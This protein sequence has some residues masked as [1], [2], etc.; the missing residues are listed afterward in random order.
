MYL[1]NVAISRHSWL[2]MLLAAA[3][4]VVCTSSLALSEEDEIKL[5]EQ[6]HRKII[7]QYGVYRDKDLQEYINKV[8]QR[9]A[10]QSSRPDLEFHFTILDDTMI[11]A[12]ALPGGYVY[13]TRGIL[14]HLN[15]E[16]ELA[17]V[18]GHEIAHVTEKHAI[19]SQNRGKALGALSTVA[20]VLTGTPGVFELGNMFGGV[21]LKGYSREFELE[22]DRV[23]ASYMAKAGYSPQ[24]MLKTIEILKAKDRIE[25]E[26]ARIEKREPRVYHG[27]LSTH[28]DND[29]RYKEA[30]KESNKLL[31]NYS[32]FIKADEFL[33]KLNGLAYGESHQVGVVRKN[34]FYHPKLGIKMAFPTGWRVET[35]S[36]GLQAVSVTADAMLGISTARYK[37][38]VDPEKFIKEGLGMSLREGR[39]V[40]IGGLPGYLGI[41]DRVETPYGPRPVRLAV[42]FDS[43][44]RIAYVLTGAGQYDLHKIASDKEFISTIFSFGRMDKDDYREARKPRLQIVRAEKGTTME[45]L[46]EQSPISNYALD[47]LRVMNGMYPNGEPEPGQLIKIVD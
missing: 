43:R 33:E 21:L 36:Q 4:L 15:S 13:V 38:G 35:T 12:F 45:S 25:I 28:P 7:A 40:N 10:K 11:N 14:T 24:A 37:R 34:R 2:S 39:E 3:S 31:K 46:A 30:I 9:I 8:G 47:K 26:E 17:A 23:G 42:L 29:T 19:R 1:M 20:A 18:L 41:A 6:E 32:E 27:F 16:S 22:A 5:G 44:K